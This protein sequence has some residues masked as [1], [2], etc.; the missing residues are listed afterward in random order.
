MEETLDP[1]SLS[2]RRRSPCEGLMPGWVGIPT[3]LPG[4]PLAQHPD[5]SEGL[6]HS[7]LFQTGE[8]EVHIT[9]TFLPKVWLQPP[10]LLSCVREASPW[11]RLPSGRGK[12][13]AKPSHSWWLSHCTLMSPNRPEEGST[14]QPFCLLPFHP[15]CHWLWKLS[16]PLGGLWWGRRDEDQACRQLVP[17]CTTWL[18]LC[19]AGWPC[20]STW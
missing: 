2:F 14:S 9:D 16:S 8:V 19:E 12:P 3:W 18:N 1:T 4:P 10:F 15:W 17:I 7:I 5:K 11:A 20:H 13:R 6:T